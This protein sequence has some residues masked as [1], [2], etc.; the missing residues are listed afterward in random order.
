MKYPPKNLPDMIAWLE[1]IRNQGEHA[2]DEDRVQIGASI[3]GLYSYPES[4]RIVESYD[5]LGGI[6]GEF[7]CDL[8]IPNGDVDELWRDLSRAIDGFVA[9]Y[10]NGTLKLNT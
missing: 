9:S 1:E 10:R 8:E 5:E 6:V 4:D 3:V 2:S 7:A